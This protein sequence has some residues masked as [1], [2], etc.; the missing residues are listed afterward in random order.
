MKVGRVHL[1][2]YVKRLFIVV[3]VSSGVVHVQKGYTD[4]PVSTFVPPDSEESW[5][6]SS[7]YFVR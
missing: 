1:Y 5:D 2:C 3:D 4:L 7:K 6:D